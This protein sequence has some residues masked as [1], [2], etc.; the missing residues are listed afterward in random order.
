MLGREGR[1]MTQCHCECKRLLPV[2]RAAIE[3][4]KWHGNPNYPHRDMPWDIRYRE[5]V[6]AV[7]KATDEPGSST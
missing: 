1:M 4:V 7:L 3:F 5:L 6:D 2:T